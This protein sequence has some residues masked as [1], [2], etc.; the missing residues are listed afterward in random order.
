MSRGCLIEL[1]NL[2]FKHSASVKKFSS[3]LSG[4]QK[5]CF[6]S[7][8]CGLFYALLQSLFWY[9]QTGVLKNFKDNKKNIAFLEM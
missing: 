5:H 6:T 1:F 3:E 4:N 2:H 9:E 8:Y 7:L